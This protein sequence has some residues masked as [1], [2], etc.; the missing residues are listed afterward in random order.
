MFYHV[1]RHTLDREEGPLLV[2]PSLSLL[3]LKTGARTDVNHAPRPISNSRP[4]RRAHQRRSL[5]LPQF[6]LHI[7]FGYLPNITAVHP[8]L[9]APALISSTVRN[10]EG[11]GY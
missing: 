11:S 3:S 2:K 4:S 8:P 9:A 1:S 5:C 7:L 10:D 6:F